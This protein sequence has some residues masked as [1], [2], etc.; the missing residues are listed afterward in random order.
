MTQW[1][2][3]PW[4]DSTSKS[5]GGKKHNLAIIDELLSGDFVEHQGYAFGGEHAVR[6][7]EAWKRFVGTYFS[8]FPD[9]ESRIDDMIA[10]G[11]KV[12]CHWTTTGT[13]KGE[14]MGIA[15]TNKRVTDTG[16]SICRMVDGK[17]VEG[18]VNW[19]VMGFFQQLGS[20]PM[21]FRKAA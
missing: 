11:D 21:E 17:I 9:I 20:L 16:I 15:P 1:T 19:D 2:I 13:H 18:W 12:V 4:S 6:G 8:A 3:R 7:R 14:F 10:E 5:C